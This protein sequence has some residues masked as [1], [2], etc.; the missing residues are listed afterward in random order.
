MD[1]KFQTSFIPKK[2]LMPTGGRI[3]TSHGISFFSI[4]VIL[5]L[6]VAL[7]GAGVVFSMERYYTNRVTTMAAELQAAEDSLNQGEIAEWVRLDKRIEIGKTLLENHLAVS[8]FF[9]LLQQMTLKSIQFRNFSYAV[10]P[11]Q[12]VAINMD[13]LADSFAALAL[14]SDELA[15]Q[16]KSIS[17]QLFSNIDQDK[18]SGKINFKFSALVDPMLI[19]YQKTLDTSGIEQ[20]S[21]VD[22]VTI[23]L[24]ETGSTTEQGRALPR[25]GGNG[26]ATTTKP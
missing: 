3:K 6:L 8:S 26:V 14:Q 13:G 23:V 4:I 18:T 12:K 16:S 2:P 25:S 15:K 20:D 11:G 22:E 5:I 19:S 9:D 10:A 24:P 17:N 21:S 1:T 7:L